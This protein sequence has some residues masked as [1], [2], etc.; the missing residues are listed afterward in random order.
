MYTLVYSRFALVSPRKS[1]VGVATL[2]A[3]SSLLSI[4]VLPR[5]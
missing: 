3:S 5:P 4:G 1:V 2:I